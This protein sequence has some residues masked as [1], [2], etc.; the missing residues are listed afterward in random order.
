M[1]MYIVSLAVDGPGIPIDLVVTDG[2][3]TPD[4]YIRDCEEAMGEDISEKLD[5]VTVI[6]EKC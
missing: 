2:E 4:D 1:S 3:Y 6:V 5:G